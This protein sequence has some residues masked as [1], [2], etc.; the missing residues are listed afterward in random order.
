MTGASEAARVVIGGLLLYLGAE[1]FVTGASALALALR[2]PELLVGLTVV[3]YGTST[4]EIIV[5]IEAA[6]AGHGQVA[7]ANVLGSNI[8]NIGLILGL[9]AL[10]SP[11]L[12]DG[13]LP[14]R[15][16]PV[17]LASTALIP[18]SLLDGSVSRREG[19]VLLLLALAYTV[20]MVGAARA[21]AVA[22][23]D[24]ALGAS[25]AGAA[26]APAARS[27]WRS[28]GMTCAGLAALLLGG[29]LFVDG[30]V[31]LAHAIGWSERVV[32]L[33]IVA[34]GTSL[35]ELLTSVTA[36]RRGHSA[37]AVGNVVGSNIFNSLLC[38]GAAALAGTVAAPI[39]VVGAELVALAVMTGLAAWLMRRAR[40]ISRMEGAVAVTLYVAFLVFTLATT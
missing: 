1:S 15:E 40:T 26:D 31:S 13:G 21:S 39:S 22:G 37:L 9:A 30:A 17:L 36:A 29:S 28:A 12:V 3:A 32:G 5:G 6:A 38:L 11:A 34:I 8:A 27:R 20:W 2:V 18:F 33:T 10:V 23:V 25:S 16:V 7:L 19:A 4:P 35:P 24:A 14:R